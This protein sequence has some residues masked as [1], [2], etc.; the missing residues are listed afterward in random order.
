MSTFKL[1][2]KH[3][4]EGFR[5]KKVKKTR[6]KSNTIRV[7]KP[8]Y[9]NSRIEK[10]YSYIHDDNYL[11][12]ESSYSESEDDLDSYSES[13]RLGVAINMN[14]INMTRS[15]LS[16]GVIYSCQDCCDLGCTETCSLKTCMTNN[17]FSIITILLEFSSSDAIMYSF[18]YMMRNEPQP[19]NVMIFI[20]KQ[21]ESSLK[22]K[23][24][25]EEYF[26][27]G[28]LVITPPIITEKNYKFIYFLME[29]GYINME[30]ILKSN[31]ILLFYKNL[32][33]KQ[34]VDTIIKVISLGVDTSF[35]MEMDSNFCK[36]WC[37]IPGV[38]Y[39]EKYLCLLY[40]SPSPRDGLL[41]RMPSSA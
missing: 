10:E 17:R 40:T 16:K 35:K 3:K 20:F 11:D 28:K 41:S 30:N 25:S 8:N 1:P 2:R 38:K 18:Q 4:F 23:E 33:L 32:L 9:S 22:N 34:D 13:E 7:R 6:T 19:L 36:N 21:I 27:D 39:L 5:R 12:S 15:L 37:D 26:V 14:N 29:N 31:V 24:D